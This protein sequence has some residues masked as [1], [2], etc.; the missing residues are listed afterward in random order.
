MRPQTVSGLR[1][2][3]GGA[4]RARAAIRDPALHIHSAYLRSPRRSRAIWRAR[5]ARSG[6]SR[7]CKNVLLCPSSVGG[8]ASGVRAVSSFRVQSSSCA[9]RAPAHP[10]AY[11]LIVSELSEM[12]EIELAMSA[13]PLELTFFYF[14]MN[15]HR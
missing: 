10:N 5:R 7:N 9:C 14:K 2:W 12:K 8:F 1:R 4:G 11:E 15:D 6:A 3:A 13:I